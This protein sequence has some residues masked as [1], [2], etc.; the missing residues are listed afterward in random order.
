MADTL[1]IIMDS[2]IG[3]Y[4]KLLYIPNDTLIHK[5][6]TITPTPTN[7]KW[8]DYLKPSIDLLIALIG[9]FVLVWKYL[10][11]KQKEFAERIIESK[12]N[13]Y[14]EFLRGFTRSAVNIMH[15]IEPNEIEDDKE[16]M[17]ARNQLLLYANDNVVKAYH[18]WVDYADKEGKDINKEVELFGK[19]LLEIRNDIHGKSKLSEEQI[20]NLNPFNRG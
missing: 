18:E 6:Y 20:S 12:R 13:A 5:I 9:A 11:Q 15:D 2:G 1:H 16:R 10:T 8:A 4:H 14:S 3:N 7:F 17:N 19:I